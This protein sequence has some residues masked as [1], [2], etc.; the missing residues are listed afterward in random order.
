MIRKLS[1]A[2]ANAAFRLSATKARKEKERNRVRLYPVTYCSE[3][4]E[5]IPVRALACFSC[6]HRQEHAEPPLQVVFCS[7]CGEDYPAKAMACFHCGHLNQ[8]HPLL[9]GAA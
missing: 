5:I 9:S 7:K 1:K 3:C 4:R 2:E 6:G 8:R